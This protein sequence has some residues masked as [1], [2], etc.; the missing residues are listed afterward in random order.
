MIMEEKKLTEEELKK[1]F[2]ILRHGSSE[3]L[4]EYVKAVLAIES[5]YNRQKAEIERLTE[6]NYKLEVIVDHNCD[7]FPKWQEAT[8]EEIAELQKQVDEL[9][10]RLDY[11]HKSSDYHEGNQKELEIKN[12]ELQKQVDELKEDNERWEAVYHIGE[13]RKYRKMFN[14]EWKK[15]YQ[16]EL[17]KQGEGLI[18][19]SPD[20]DYVYELYFKQKAEI[21]RLKTI[22]EKIIASKEDVKSRYKAEIKELQTQ[23]IFDRE[24]A[25]WDG[26]NE[27]KSKA[28][29]DTAKEIFIKQLANA[30]RLKEQFNS[31]TYGTNR[32]HLIATIEIEIEGIKNLAKRYGV[33]VE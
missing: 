9:T 4:S 12:A 25:F 28:V 5:E 15:E 8:I 11:F 18:A 17:D 22:N 16:K 26:V 6:E 30:K 7:P 33:E 3:G 21:E 2:F 32:E 24:G 14:E 23:C 13:E 1:A 20:F 19:G 31:T 27:G 29:K 10:Q